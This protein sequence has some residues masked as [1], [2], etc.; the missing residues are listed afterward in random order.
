[1]ICITFIC[2]SNYRTTIP[3]DKIKLLPLMHESCQP[4]FPV[5]DKN[6][7]METPLHLKAGNLTRVK[8]NTRYLHV[9]VVRVP[10][11]SNR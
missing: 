9:I 5:K 2:E 8:L 3:N 6:Q 11:H 4:E 10:Q 7:I 1:M